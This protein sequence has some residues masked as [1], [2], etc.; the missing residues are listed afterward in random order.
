MRYLYLIL[1]PLLLT[2]C[3][4]TGLEDLEEFVRTSD[5]DMRG[6]IPPAAEVKPYEVFPYKNDATPPLP[7]PFQPRK[8]IKNGK[9]KELVE[10]HP[11]EELENFPLENLKMVGFLE[12]K[13]VPEAIIRSPDNRVF[14]VRV[15]HYMGTKFGIIT[16]ISADGVTIREIVRENEQDEGTERFSTLQLDEPGVAK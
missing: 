16:A 8:Q 12:Q 9:D 14:R 11:K 5:K 10:D 6:N 2:A 7:D 13:N 4:G 3:M 1:A 15:G